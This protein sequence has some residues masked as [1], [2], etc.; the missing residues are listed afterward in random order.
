MVGSTDHGNDPIEEG[1]DHTR[2][3]VPVLAYG[4]KCKS[5]VNLG[6]RECFADAGATVADILGVKLPAIGKSF[7]GE[8][9]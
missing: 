8:I 1:T 9:L 3:Y 5:G 4:K 2:E 6:T 7:K